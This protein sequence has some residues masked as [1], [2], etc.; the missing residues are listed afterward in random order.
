VRFIRVPEPRFRP[1]EYISAL[2]NVVASERID[3]CI[4]ILE[5]TFYIAWGI[6]QFP[7]GCI[8]WA[9]T[10]EKLDMLHN[11]LTFIEHVKTMGFQTPKTES[12]SSRSELM[13][14]LTRFP[15][16]KVVM[17]PVYSRFGVR[18]FIWSRGESVPTAIQPT[19]T[20]SW[21]VQEFIDG[22]PLVT[23]S[24]AKRDR[25]LH[26]RIICCNSNGGSGPLCILNI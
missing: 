9:D 5:E 21:I 6:E 26:T 20:Q 22:R 4:P 17:K 10:I 19:E 15:S 1:R 3:V 13:S 23:W 18:A 24:L 12:V 25:C 11:K 8:V 7:P 16:D 14:C 2:S